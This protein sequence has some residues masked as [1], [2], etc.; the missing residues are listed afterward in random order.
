[1]IIDLPSLSQ[2]SELRALW[3]EAFGDSEEFF[4]LFLN[5]AYS[6]K[7]CRVLMLDGS[8]VAALYWFDCE[9][10][11]ERIA[12][13]Y[14]IA[15]KKA[16]RGRGICQA[17]MNDTHAHLTALGYAAAILVPSEPS[18]FGFY[19]RIG[20]TPC[21]SIQEF[22]CSASGENITLTQIDKLE[23][24]SL[25][26]KYLPAKSV[27]QEKE[28]LD[29]LT[30]QAK[31]YKGDGVLL[32]AHVQGDKLIGLEL[33][34]DTSLSPRL[35]KAFGCSSG[36]FRSVGDSRRFAMYLPLDDKKLSPP[37]YLGFAFD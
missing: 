4:D 26:R 17:L 14:A 30:A 15:T 7:R 18:L 19:E 34:G 37:A 21:S 2:T 8:V 5:T 12:Y 29:F 22:S 1:M 31:L 32:A 11:G 10:E 3:C 35:V 16:Y 6:S 28:N 23:Y 36:E 20:Y 13:L 27:I 24:A 25:R 33:L 9:Y